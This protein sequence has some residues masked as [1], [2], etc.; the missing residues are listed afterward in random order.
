MAATGNDNSDGM[1]PAAS[2]KRPRKPYQITRPREK[3]AA[4]EHG[5]FLHALTLFGRDWKRIEQF[6]STKTATQVRSHAQKYF[7]KAQKLGLGAALPPPH[8]R[9]S[10]VLAA[11]APRT[12]QSQ[13][14][15]NAVLAGTSA[16]A[17]AQMWPPTS[18]M[19]LAAPSGGEQQSQSADWVRTS[20]EAHHWSSRSGGDP[21]GAGWVAGAMLAQES[22][23][24]SL[25]LPPGDPRFAMVYRFV[26]D[27]F[28]SGA[29]RPVEEQLQRLQGVDLAVMETILLV[30]RN[31]QDNLFA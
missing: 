8:P 22:E 3:W 14:D 4:D 11:D 6:V 25:P 18:S 30:L 10:A 26:G 12:S 9:R 23:T 24:I 29:A 20:S 13:P 15:D 19:D 21:S 31:L 17:A 5:R 2:G 1:P 16:A 7:L 27:V 28:G